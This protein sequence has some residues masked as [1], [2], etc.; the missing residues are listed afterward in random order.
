MGRAASNDGTSNYLGT[1]L[2]ARIVIRGWVQL[3]LWLLLGFSVQKGDKGGLN[4]WRGECERWTW[5]GREMGSC[6][7]HR[8]VYVYVCVRIIYI[9]IMRTSGWKFITA[10]AASDNMLYT[11]MRSVYFILRLVEYRNDPE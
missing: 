10:A 6:T 3:L 9:Y 5:S 1:R 8:A 7:R 4:G 2:L 11:Y